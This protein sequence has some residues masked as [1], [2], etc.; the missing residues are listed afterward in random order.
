M[1]AHFVG[2]K[3]I[4]WVLL[5]LACSL[6]FFGVARAQD[7]SYSIVEPPK[8]VLDGIPFSVDIEAG[9]SPGDDVQLRVAGE[10]YE[11]SFS[12][13][14]ATVEDIVVNETGDIS[15]AVVAGGEQVTEE[16]TNSI[17]GWFSILP[18]L[19]AIAVALLTRQVVPAL[20]LGIYI[21]AAMA[22]GLSL[23]CFMVRPG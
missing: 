15:M 13:G 10:S 14:M 9:S 12:D 5:L 4:L 7:G 3:L 8:T 1:K 16:S 2:S 17:P 23:G 6:L 21:G 18:P 20:F 11:A 22:Y 19:L